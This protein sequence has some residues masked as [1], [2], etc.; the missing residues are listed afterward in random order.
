MN[1]DYGYNMYGNFGQ[2][3]YGNR[4]NTQLPNNQYSLN[5]RPQMRE[6]TFVNGMEG[7]KAFMLP[8]NQSMLLMDSDHMMCYM[9]QSDEYGK[10]TMRFFILQEV[11]E[12]GARQ[13]LQP[14]QESQGSYVSKEEF[15]ALNKK[16]D[17]LIRRLDKNNNKK[18]NKDN[19]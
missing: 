8:P 16:I 1:N 12:A 4:Q 7:A 11:D 2:N 10:S 17:E 14:A 15:D 6:Y 9:K 3:V 13:F 18:D 19:G 5:N